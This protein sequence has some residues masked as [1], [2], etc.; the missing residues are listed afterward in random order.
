LASTLFEEE[1]MSSIP[2]KRS[3]EGT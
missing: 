2:V 1:S 3:Y